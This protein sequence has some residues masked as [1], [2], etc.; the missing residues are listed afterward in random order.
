[1]QTKG[2]KRIDDAHLNITSLK[3]RTW[4]QLWC[5]SRLMIEKLAGLFRVVNEDGSV[6]S[7]CGRFTLWI[8]WRRISRM[9]ERSR[10]RAPY[11]DVIESPP[12]WI[13][14]STVDFK[15]FK[16]WPTD[17][18]LKGHRVDRSID[19][20]SFGLTRN[21]LSWINQH[22]SGRLFKSI[23][24]W[25]SHSKRWRWRWRRRERREKS[26]H[27]VDRSGIYRRKMPLDQS[28]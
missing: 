2:S 28:L 1:M 7:W 13:N 26:K 3:T 27:H 10:S 9:A 17:G 18:T 15:V 24:F 25:H 19:R 14:S 22:G 11:F 6:F 12:N 5:K 4:S 20:S 8:W 21:S 23:H 16:S